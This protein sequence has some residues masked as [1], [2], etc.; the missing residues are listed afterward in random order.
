MFTEIPSILIVS[1]LFV[2]AL[3]LV[4]YGVARAITSN[5]LQDRIHTYATIPDIASRGPR[6]RRRSSLAALRYRINTSLS[7]FNSEKL[8]IELIRADWQMSVTEFL[9]IRWG[10]TILCLLVGWLIS[11]LFLPGIGMALIAYFIASIYL[12]RS[13]NKRK[14]AFEK[15]LLDVLILINGAVRSGFSL[16]Q[17]LELV[18]K[19]M[20]SPASEEFGRVIQ[21]ASLGVSLPMALHNLAARMR[22]DDLDLVVTAVDIHHSIGGNLATMLATVSETIRER[23][24]LFGEIRVVTT[25]QRYTGYLLSLLPFFIGSAMFIINPEY[26]LRLFEPGMMLCIPLGSLLGIIA[27]HL[28]IQRIARI[29]V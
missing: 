13:I 26:I 29:N 20:K 12:H 22:N 9:L 11:R 15:Q 6:L 17:A 25:Q 14:L 7:S 18:V 4:V 24:R 23:I 28:A 8:S 27:G 19:E 10:I 2:L 3:V 21:E 16:L 5:L 1:I